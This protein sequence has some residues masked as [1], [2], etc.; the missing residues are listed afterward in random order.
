MSAEAG[1]SG[2]AWLEILRPPNLPT[3]PGD[4]LAGGLLAVSAGCAMDA[5][6]L[7]FAAVS[8]LLLYAAGLVW[9]DCFDVEQ[10][11]RERPSRPIPSGRVRLPGARSAATVLSIAGVGAGFLAG[12]AAGRMACLV[13]V[14]VLLYD[15]LSK[16]LPVAGPVNMGLCRGGSVLLGAAAVSG[17][18]IPPVRSTAGAA[19]VACYV[20]V[21][22][23]MARTEV[24]GGPVTPALIGRLIR[25]LLLLQAVLCALAPWPGVIAAAVLLAMWLP[26]TYLSRSFYGS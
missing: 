11:R 23:A 21:V 4:P 12:N 26:A 22:T 13:L 24:T 8:A 16:R 1:R 19:V 15:A 17:R 25:G 14:L 10:D 7:L 5:G 20:A 9:N 18:L 6:R 2:R 3:V